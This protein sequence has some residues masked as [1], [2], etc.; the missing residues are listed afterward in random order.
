MLFARVGRI[1]RRH[2]GKQV[3]SPLP[4]PFVPRRSILH[5]SRTYAR[6]ASVPSTPR[7][8]MF[9]LSPPEFSHHRH[10]RRGATRTRVRDVCVLHS[11]SASSV[12]GLSTLYEKK[13]KRSDGDPLC[14][15]VGVASSWRG[16]L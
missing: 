8:R 5:A 16:G 13:T 4:N 9:S 14:R 10:A 7:T 3:V 11:A 2:E 1:A 6:D 12:T 15:F